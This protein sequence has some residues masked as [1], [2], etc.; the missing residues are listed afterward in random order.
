M[1]FH[2]LANFCRC[3]LL[4]RKITLHLGATLSRDSCLHV[5]FSAYFSFLFLPTFIFHLLSS[6]L[7]TLC[8][9]FFH[10]A[11]NHLLCISDSSD[12]VLCSSRL[13]PFA[14]ITTQSIPFELVSEHLHQDC[15]FW[16]F[17]CYLLPAWVYWR[18]LCHVFDPASSKESARLS[19]PSKLGIWPGILGAIALPCR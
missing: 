4:L 6:F 7:F 5:G 2:S 8:L 10:S 12:F 9:Q 16:L 15:P 1:V 11:S 14:A 17:D 13:A 19:T 18:Q 3:C